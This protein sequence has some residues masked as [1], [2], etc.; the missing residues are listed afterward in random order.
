M[1]FIPVGTSHGSLEEEVLGIPV[2]IG[3]P[4]DGLDHVV[5]ALH[6]PGGYGELCMVDDTHHV[7]LN[8]IAE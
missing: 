3:F 5:D 4:P 2:A 7:P 8:R 1:G 6:L